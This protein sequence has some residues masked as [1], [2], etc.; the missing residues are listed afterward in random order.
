[1][2]ER[3][4]QLVSEIQQEKDSNWLVKLAQELNQLLDKKGSVDVK[5]QA[6]NRER[7]VCPREWNRTKTEQEKGKTNLSRYPRF[8]LLS[9]CPVR[10]LSR[11]ATSVWVSASSSAGPWLNPIPNQRGWQGVESML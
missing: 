7:D 11:C 4:R 8:I 5:T 1:M 10:T 3:I 9:I 2:E 6:E